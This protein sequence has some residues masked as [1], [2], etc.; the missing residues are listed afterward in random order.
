LKVFVRIGQ[1]PN[2]QETFVVLLLNVKIF[3]W[4]RF[5]VLMRAVESIKLEK[6]L[7]VQII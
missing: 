7:L 2:H 4:L 1:R 6:E 3:R 5:L